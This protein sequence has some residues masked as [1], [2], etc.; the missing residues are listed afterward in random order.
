MPLLGAGAAA[1]AA[2]AGGG[3]PAFSRTVRLS[4][5]TIPMLATVASADICR[6]SSTQCW[7]SSSKQ[8]GVHAYMHACA[9]VPPCRGTEWWSTAAQQ[10]H[11][12]SAPSSA[13]S[14]WWVAGDPS[15][16]QG[17]GRETPQQLLLV[18]RYAGVLLDQ[19][20]QLGTGRCTLCL[21]GHSGLACG[22]PDA[23]GPHHVC[24]G[25]SCDG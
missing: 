3:A 5:L 13:S 11:N 7:M 20:L 12:N 23:Q 4:P 15:Y 22:V 6:H 1:P 21:K 10:Q 9:V 17:F 18:W 19:L 14:S 16:L 25:Y 2:P 8:D 24:A